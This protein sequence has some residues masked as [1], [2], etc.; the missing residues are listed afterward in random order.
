MLTLGTTL[1]FTGAAIATLSSLIDSGRKLR[2]H[3]HDVTPY[4]GPYVNRH[5][6]EI[7]P[8]IGNLSGSDKRAV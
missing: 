3:L 4:V 5:G 2:R 6:R 1:I 8:G 7:R